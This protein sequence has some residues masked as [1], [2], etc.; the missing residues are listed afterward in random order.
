MLQDGSATAN[1]NAAAT[2]V[3]V[4]GIGAPGAAAPAAS[5]DAVALAAAQALGAKPG[6]AAGGINI[7]SSAPMALS[8]PIDIWTKQAGLGLGH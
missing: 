5:A 1:A 4:A 2:A 3:P 7:V 6:G 8:N